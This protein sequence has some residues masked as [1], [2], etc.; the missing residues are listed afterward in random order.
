VT[1]YFVTAVLGDKSFILYYSAIESAMARDAREAVRGGW[2]GV[3][4]RKL[5][6]TQQDA[7]GFEEFEERAQAHRDRLDDW[8][9]DGEYC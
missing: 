8:A 5:S 3:R 7:D 4:L 2:K 1:V 9:S 6:W